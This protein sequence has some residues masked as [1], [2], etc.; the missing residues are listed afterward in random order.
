M[1][2]IM[3]V[4]FVIA[5]IASLVFPTSDGFAQQLFNPIDSSQE[6]SEI[7]INSLKP[8]T[9]CDNGCGGASVY[10]GT[11]SFPRKLNEGNQTKH[12]KGSHNYDAK[13]SSFYGTKKSAEDFVK[14]FGG[15][16]QR[17]S[18]TDNKERVRMDYNVGIY[19]NAKGD[20][21]MPSKNAMIVWGK[22]GGHVYAAEP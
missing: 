18:G 8:G 19:R 9:G 12:I 5:I 13:R 14:R 11:R 20:Y 22:N 10:I 17:V 16:G 15:K 1:K 7:G 3:S 4:S 2:K 6:I 21:E